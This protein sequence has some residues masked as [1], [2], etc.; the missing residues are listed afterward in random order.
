MARPANPTPTWDPKR[1]VWV[2]RVTVNGVQRP[3]DLQGPD[4]LPRIRQDQPE[5]AQAV[6]KILSDGLRA[7][8]GV[9]PCGGETVASW[10]VRRYKWLAGRPRTETL[11][12]R[13]R[14]WV[15]WINPILGPLAIDR[16]TADDVRR[17][18]HHLEV[19]VGAEKIAPKTALNLYGEVTG[20]FAD[21]CE[22]NDPNIRVRNDNPCTLVRGPEKGDE[23]SKPFLRP[24]EITALLSCADVPCYRRELYAVAIYTAGRIGELRALTPADVDFDAM[25]ITIAKQAGRMG[26][27]KAKTKTRRARLVRIEPSLL[28]LLRILVGRKGKTLLNVANEDH[29]R[30]LREDLVTAKVTRAA[31][32]ADDDLRMP[33]T[34]HG[35]RDTC[36]SHMAVRRDPPQDIQWRAGHASPIMTEKYIGQAKYEAGDNFGTP[37]PGLPT[38]FLVSA[39]RGEF[40]SKTAFLST[41]SCE[42]RELNPYRSN[43]AGT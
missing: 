2:V 13:Q 36:L 30:L 8:Q 6:A 20:A 29:A 41:N 25:Q 35:L 31:L 21:A 43:P 39:R 33:L 16:V 15:R 26:E 14:A 4:D 27:A 32:F 24:A 5:V 23:R 28:P 38:P 40:Q 12:E 10:A 18:V 19:A 11:Q 1:L 3:H 22:A 42:G 37:F 7:G 17:L 9:A 34:F